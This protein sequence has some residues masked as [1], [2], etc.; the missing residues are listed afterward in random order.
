MSLRYRA[1]LFLLRPPQGR[2]DPCRPVPARPLRASRRRDRRNPLARG[3]SANAPSCSVL[4]D[5]AAGFR[6]TSEGY[7]LSQ[8]IASATPSIPRP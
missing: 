4:T 2:T 5:E 8:A 6:P 1:M 7:L 3:V